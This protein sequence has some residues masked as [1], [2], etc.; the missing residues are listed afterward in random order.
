M[1]RSTTQTATKT[2]MPL[3]MQVEA[4]KRTALIVETTDNRL[5]SVC[6]A[7]NGLEHLWLGAPVK[8]VRGEWVP[9]RGKEQ[10][11]RRAGCR[12]LRGAAS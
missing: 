8:M 6:A 9:A 11:V 2:V 4:Y 10:L 1:P 5:F 12:F 7:P 3:G